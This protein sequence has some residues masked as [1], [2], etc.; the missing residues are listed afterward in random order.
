MVDSKF[1]YGLMCDW[2]DRVENTQISDLV[3]ISNLSGQDHTF[4]IVQS[5][6]VDIVILIILNTE[7]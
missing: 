3:K 7:Y 4:M 5:G 2:I 1:G 6:S